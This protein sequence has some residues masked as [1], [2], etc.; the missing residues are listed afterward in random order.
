MQ[1][2][3]TNPNV[4]YAGK[5]L[6]RDR[7]A[8]I[9]PTPDPTVNYAGSTLPQD[10]AEPQVFTDPT[11]TP[12]TV[13]LGGILMSVDTLTFLNGKKILV[14]THILD[15]PSVFERISRDPCEIEFEGVLRMQNQG[16]I[17]FYNT[18]SAPP[19]L[20]GPLNNVFA[21][22]YMNDVW[23][24][25][26]LPDSVLNVK[27]SFLNGINISELVIETISVR[28]RRGSTDIA[29]KIKAFE[30]VPGQSLIIS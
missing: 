1:I 18:N 16:G 9:M 24:N 19:G 10:A 22:Q 14:L 26:Y 27:N 30:N 11:N 8:V 5:V 12:G 29:F 4:N 7:A 25:C 6:P 28:P 21:Q 2:I 20:T 17:N 3:I 13:Q 23:T 15:G